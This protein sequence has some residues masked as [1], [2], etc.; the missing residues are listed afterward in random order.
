MKDSS[1]SSD[2]LMLPI[3]PQAKQ[4]SSCE[5]RTFKR[6]TEFRDCLKRTIKLRHHLFHRLF[7]HQ[8][9]DR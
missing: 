5:N 1:P 4:N 9:A 8:S 6:T 3:S 2:S 7:G